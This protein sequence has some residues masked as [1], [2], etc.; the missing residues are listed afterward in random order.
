MVNVPPLVLFSRTGPTK[1]LLPARVRLNGPI[2][3]TWPVPL[4][5][6]ARITAPRP[7]PRTMR[8]VAS[9]AELLTTNTPP[10]C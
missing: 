10:P 8:L 6:P 9:T 2:M 4:I 1:L 3:V 5:F 7:G